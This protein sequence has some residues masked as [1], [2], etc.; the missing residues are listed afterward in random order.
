[1][2]NALGGAA[3]GCMVVSKQKEKE[4]NPEQKRSM[5]VLMLSSPVTIRQF[6]TSL[7]D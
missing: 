5:R 7:F 2:R 4:A 3:S 1:M 6:T